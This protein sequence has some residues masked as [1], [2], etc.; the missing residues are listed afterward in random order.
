MVAETVR[1]AGLGATGKV[2][3]PGNVEF[4]WREWSVP[5]G[6]PKTFILFVHGVGEHS[7]RYGE[8]GRFFTSRGVPVVSFDLRGFGQSGGPR[9]HVDRFSDYVD[10][11]MFFRDWA[12]ARYPGAAAILVG[13]SLGGLI[14]LTTA[15]AHGSS[16]AAVIVSAPAL[17]L[18]F[19]V[20]GWKVLL[21]RAAARLAPR[22]TVTNEL[23]PAH[24]ARNPEVGRR[25][26]ADPLVTNRVSAGW[27]AAFTQAMADAMA[28]AGR[29]T[30]PTLILQGTDDRMVDPQASRA[31]YERLGDGPKAFRS[32]EG[33]YHELFQEDEREQVFAAMWEW[34]KGQR[35]LA[36]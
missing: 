4:L 1:D 24:L 32:W 35:L 26:V 10:D 33:F 17:G 30:I 13:H 11:V 20:P 5:G 21:G 16:F 29:L 15:E 7:G 25:Y 19:K 23:N 6:T 28:E 2:L 14:A 22:L 18:A 27:Y 31:F 9:G 3:G 12:Q 8:F 34:M 36:A